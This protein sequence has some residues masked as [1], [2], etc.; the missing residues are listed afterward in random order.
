MTRRPVAT[1]HQV[2]DRRRRAGSSGGGGGDRSPSGA[3]S[4]EA[5][6]TGASGRGS[7]GD[8]SLVVTADPSS[9]RRERRVGA[10]AGVDLDAVAVVALLRQRGGPALA[11]ASHLDAVHRQAA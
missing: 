2:R 9:L 11:I 5:W 7:G 10:G 4:G 6:P 1:S 8:R 3:P